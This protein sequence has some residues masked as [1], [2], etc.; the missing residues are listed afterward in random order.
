[1]NVTHHQEAQMIV[2]GESERGISSEHLFE[3]EVAEEDITIYMD[4]MN[5]NK[6]S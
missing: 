5:S 4:R 1:M 2:Q 3:T 6:F